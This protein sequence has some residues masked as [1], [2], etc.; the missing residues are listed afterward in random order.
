MKKISLFLVLVLAFL[1]VCSCGNKNVCSKEGCNQPTYQD[2]LCKDHYDDKQIKDAAG[3]LAGAVN[4][5]F[6]GK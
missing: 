4:S 2:G 6:G 1:S 3:N 5:F